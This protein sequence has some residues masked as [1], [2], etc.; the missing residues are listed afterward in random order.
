MYALANMGRPSRTSHR[1]CEMK[2][3]LN[4]FS[5]ASGKG[6][7]AYSPRHRWVTLGDWELPFGKGKQFAGNLPKLA[8][9]LVG[10]WRLSGIATVS[11]GNWLTPTLILPAR[12]A[13]L[14]AQVDF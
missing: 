12:F 1:D 3:A 4:P 9:A 10:G 13:K 14:T 6:N 5:L 2:S 11:T 8:D 7:V